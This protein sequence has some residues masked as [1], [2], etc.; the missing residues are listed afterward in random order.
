MKDKAEQRA[1]ALSLREIF[2]SSGADCCLHFILWAKMGM[3]EIVRP[4]M[5]HHSITLCRKEESF[6]KR[7]TKSFATEFLL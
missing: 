5:V 4:E 2:F 1:E 3:G 7:R 6:E